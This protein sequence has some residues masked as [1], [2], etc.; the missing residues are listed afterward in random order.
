MWGKQKALMRKIKDDLNKR[1]AV[2]GSRIEDN[3]NMAIF[4]IS[5]L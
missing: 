3:I 1:T 4:S 5:D 2:T